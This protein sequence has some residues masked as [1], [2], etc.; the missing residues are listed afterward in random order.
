[1]FDEEF[2]QTRRGRTMR[3][4]FSLTFRTQPLPKMV[5]RVERA[6][7]SVEAVFGDYDR[8]P[9]HA[10]ADAWLILARKP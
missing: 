7:Y 9:W 4:R 3:R 2:V 6:G 10:R 8:S 5:A 1:V